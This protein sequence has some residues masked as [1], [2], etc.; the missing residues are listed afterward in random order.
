[1]YA[2]R[3]VLV[4]ATRPAR[5]APRWRLEPVCQ[6]PRLLPRSLHPFRTSRDQHTPSKLSGAQLL[7]QRFRLPLFWVGHPHHW[8]DVIPRL[9]SIVGFEPCPSATQRSSTGASYAKPHSPVLQPVLQP[10]SVRTQRTPSEDLLLL[11]HTHGY[12]RPMLRARSSYDF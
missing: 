3:S 12:L 1:M 4:P 8:A 5:K 2:F 11:P 7:A 9:F 10:V 6:R